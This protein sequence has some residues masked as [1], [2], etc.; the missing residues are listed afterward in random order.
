MTI[1]IDNYIL[2]DNVM[3]QKWKCTNI[4]GNGVNTD[5]GSFALFARSTQRHTTRLMHKK[6]HNTKDMSDM[7]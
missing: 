1:L 6:K 4:I 3:L 2:N 7:G 5:R